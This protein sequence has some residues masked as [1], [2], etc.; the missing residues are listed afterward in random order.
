MDQLSQIINNFSIQ[1]GV[2]YT[3]KLCGLSSF[4]QPAI[5]GH[6]HILKSGQLKIT[7][8]N[9]ED[10]ELN[11][12]SIVF[13]PRPKSHRL[14]A[15]ESDQAE[16]ICATVQ[17][18][19]G[20][21]NPVA[22]ALPNVLVLPLSEATQLLNNLDWILSEAFD[23]RLG[24][25]SVLNRLMEIFIV[26]LLRHLIEHNKI[27][28]G[29]LAGMAHKQ[30]NK[31]LNA[32]HCQPEVNWTIESMADIALMSRAKFAPLFKEVIGQT[33]LEY[34]TQWRV[35]MAQKRLLDGKSVAIVANEVG[36]ESPSTLSRAF[37][38]TCKLSP[39]A[40]LKATMA[41]DE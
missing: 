23:Q 3:G 17:Y 36:Y 1:A 18:G 14:V 16:V 26:S 32:L 24:S 20:N 8:L 29:M 9:Q 22:Q 37:M 5:E 33:P 25:Q 10:I 13:F 35:S 12:P 39:K 28:Q 15:S 2:F 40:W 38:K 19:V 27:E 21:V 31:V 30:L 34:L 6:I 11:E 4:E 41:N 7:G